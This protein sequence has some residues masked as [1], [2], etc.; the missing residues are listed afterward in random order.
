MTFKILLCGDDCVDVYQYGHVERLS[1][2]AP[3]P[4]VKLDHFKKIA[5]MAGN[6]KRNLQALNCAVDYKHTDTNVKTRML[7]IKSY[8][9]MLRIDD[10]KN[11]QPLVANFA[12]TAYDA[13]VISDYCKG[14]ITYEFVEQL[15]REFAGPIFVDTKKK[16]LK[17]FDGCFVKINDFEYT[18]IT[19]EPTDLIVTRGAD[20]CT[21]HGKTYPTEQVEVVDVCGA[22]DTFLATLCYFY[23]KTQNIDSAIMSANR[24]ASVTVKHL[25]VYAP[26][27]NEFENEQTKQKP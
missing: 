11:C 5:G 1:P 24:A 18:T 19:S 25:G 20:G 2:E 7:D 12:L 3:V 22:G 23:L 13:I 16:D 6:V 10:D 9:H 8:Q 14:T 17:R 21:F 27:L 4:I 26:S 15:R